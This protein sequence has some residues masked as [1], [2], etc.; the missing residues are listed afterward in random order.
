VIVLDTTVLV[1]AIGID[2][3]RR[4]QCRRIV[5]AI[6]D[7]QVLATTTAEVIQEFTYVRAR[8]R[9]RNEAAE[10]AREFVSLLTP[11][12]RPDEGDLRCGLEVYAHHPQVGSFDAVLAATVMNRPHLTA[13]V[14]ADRGFATVPGLVHLDPSDPAVLA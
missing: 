8:R 2:H 12:L 14:S 10:R 5:T 3:P 9:T 4:E 7:G 1:H 11:L 13:L 6:R